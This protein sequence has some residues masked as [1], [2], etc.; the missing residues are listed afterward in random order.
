MTASYIPRIV[1]YVA[2][3]IG[4]GFGIDV[5]I[6]MARGESSD[7]IHVLKLGGLYKS[8]GL[9]LDVLVDG[10]ID[11]S[12]KAMIALRFND[13]VIYEHPV[14]VSECFNANATA[15]LG[16]CFA[17]HIYSEI[18]SILRA[19]KPLDDTVQYLV[20][21]GFQVSKIKRNSSLSNFEAEIHSDE[22]GVD[23]RAIIKTSPPVPTNE[24]DAVIYIPT[25]IARFTDYYA[26]SY[27]MNEAIAKVNPMMLKH[28]HGV[29]ASVSGDRLI[30]HLEGIPRRMLKPLVKAITKTVREVENNVNALLSNADQPDILAVYLLTVRNPLY[31]NIRFLIPLKSSVIRDT[32]IAYMKNKLGMEQPS[33]DISLLGQLY[34][35]GVLGIDNELHLVLN[36]TRIIDIVK[37]YT[38]GRTKL[39]SSG[40]DIEVEE[41][42]L[43]SYLMR[44]YDLSTEQF[45]SNTPEIDVR[46]VR[47]ILDS[48]N[49][50]VGINERT[51]S[52]LRNKDLWD[53]MT[54]E[55]KC[56]LLR[57]LVAHT[58]LHFIN[59]ARENSWTWVFEDPV[60]VADAIWLL[61]NNNKQNTPGLITKNLLEHVP[62]LFGERF[63]VIYAGGE[64]FV[65]IGRVILQVRAV[66]YGKIEAH[67]TIGTSRIGIVAYGRSIQEVAKH[68]T[69]DLVDT[70]SE[71]TEIAEV[72]KTRSNIKIDADRTPL[73]TIPVVRITDM[74]TQHTLPLSREN[75]EVVKKYLS[76]TGI[77]ETEREKVPA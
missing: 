69:D 29:F 28:F 25:S 12:R 13:E 24:M 31:D 51:V 56:L 8:S 3:Y 77:S 43:V 26:W 48:D 60:V 30:A 42:R 10:T 17:K 2:E 65:K 59:L 20:N 39:S 57:S 1:E 35:N 38:G 5:E 46:M 73:F 58:S 45:L 36:G 76:Q 34:E 54:L 11:Q 44:I 32:A 67:G 19:T 21:T 71:F 49:L 37:K 18:S 15:K 52:L 74:D 27:L 4:R 61:S 64:P 7:I 14:P 22:L 50:D 9:R 40:V 16:D 53:K 72:A 63:D 6:D 33:T 23:I 70:V 75:L 68:I 62:E 47:I 55:A 66:V 41:G